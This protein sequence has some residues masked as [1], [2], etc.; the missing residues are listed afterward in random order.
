MFSQLFLCSPQCIIHIYPSITILNLHPSSPP[1]V[2]LSSVSDAGLMQP[3]IAVFT[4]LFAVCMGREA[5]S[6]Q[7]TA[8]ILVAV[9]GAV[10][11]VL[12]EGAATGH[13]AT[14]APS[15]PPTPSNFT[16][17]VNASS[18]SSGLPLVH[19]NPASATASPYRQRTLGLLAFVANCISFSAYIIF[20]RPLLDRFPPLSLSFWTFV[21]GGAVQICV[22]A[23][24]SHRVPWAALPPSTWLGLVYLALAGTVVTFFTFSFAVLHLPA[25]IAALGVCLQPLFSSLLGAL[26]MHDRITLYHV[27]GGLTICAGVVAVYRGR[28]AEQAAA[29]EEALRSS[30]LDADKQKRWNEWQSQRQSLQEEVD[31]LETF[32]IPHAI[33]VPPLSAAEVYVATASSARQNDSVDEHSWRQ[34]ALHRLEKQ[35]EANNLKKLSS[36]NALN[37]SA[38]TTSDSSAL[39]FSSAPSSVSKPSFI[40][41][42]HAHHHTTQ[43]ES[44]QSIVQET[45]TRMQA[46]TSID[47]ELV[48]NNDGELVLVPKS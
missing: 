29:Q 12:G 16:D 28:A 26:M 48:L 9:A 46:H 23:S 31:M 20:Q 19:M 43:P 39:T 36:M 13:A 1:G 17:F 8:G 44:A 42:Q 47:V 24:L 38:A 4:S 40:V 25:S 22:G 45:T 5:S 35:V 7:K 15:L 21:F 27:L 3:C 33:H 34:S 2:Y 41:H 32:G 37:S 11:I 30:Q 10:L 14:V 18:S 6:L